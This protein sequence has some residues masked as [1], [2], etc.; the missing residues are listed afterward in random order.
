MLQCFDRVLIGIVDNRFLLIAT[1]ILALYPIHLTGGNDILAEARR[2]NLDVLQIAMYTAGPT[3]VLLVIFALHQWCV[4][5]II[6]AFETNLSWVL[7]LRNDRFWKDLSRVPIVVAV[8]CVVFVAVGV[9]MTVTSFCITNCIVR[10]SVFMIVVI[11]SWPMRVTMSSQNQK[12]SQVRS[13]TKRADDEDE[14]WIA[15]FGRVDKSSDGFQYDR[16]AKRDEEDGIEKGA[17]DFSP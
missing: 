2:M 10:V 7:G 9:T 14:L 6:C 8:C 3:A 12:A 13:E 1:S 15:D 11:L 16:K 5:G 17:E 4:L